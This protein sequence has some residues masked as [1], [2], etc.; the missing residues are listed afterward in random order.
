[1]VGLVYVEI[2]PLC[3]T[4]LLTNIVGD[5][6]VTA[7]PIDRCPFGEGISFLVGSTSSFVNIVTPHL[8]E[9]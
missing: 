5:S 8:V 7:C 1:M 3:G 2:S 9:T 4:D 6:S